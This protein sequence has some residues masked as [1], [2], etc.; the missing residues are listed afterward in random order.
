MEEEI[1]VL[2]VT[3]MRKV[4]ALELGSIIQHRKKKK[5]NAFFPMLG[6]FVS[7]HSERY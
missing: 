1:S 4:S 2:S 5:K 7:S 6:F 3:L